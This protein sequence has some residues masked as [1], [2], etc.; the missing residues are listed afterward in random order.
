MAITTSN[1]IKVKPRREQLEWESMFDSST[2]DWHAVEGSR[3]RIRLFDHHL[4]GPT[5][6]DPDNPGKAGFHHVQSSDRVE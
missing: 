6:P 3:D 5:G 1:S 2:G 4:T